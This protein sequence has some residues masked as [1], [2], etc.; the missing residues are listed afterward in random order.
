MRT[1]KKA[2]YSKIDVFEK[3]ESVINLEMRGQIKKKWILSIWVT[4]IT[5]MHYRQNLGRSRAILHFLWVL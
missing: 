4:R 1:F 3:F 2:I 5:Y